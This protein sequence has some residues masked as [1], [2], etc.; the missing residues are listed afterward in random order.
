MLAIVKVRLADATTAIVQRRSTVVARHLIR[1]LEG[2]SQSSWLRLAGELLFCATRSQGL[3]RAPP[4]DH[5][6]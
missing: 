4:F 6:N 1:E 2:F 5:R 3:G